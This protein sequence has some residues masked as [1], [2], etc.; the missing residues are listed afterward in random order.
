VRHSHCKLLRS[1]LLSIALVSYVVAHAVAQQDD[2]DARFDAMSKSFTSTAASFGNDAVTTWKVPSAFVK[3]QFIAR[4]LSSAIANAGITVTVSFPGQ[5]VNAPYAKVT[6]QSIDPI[7]C[8]ADRGC[9]SDCGWDLGCIAAKFDCERIKAQEKLFCE[10]KK[11]AQGAISDKL[12]L[13]VYLYDIDTGESDKV[14][15][16]SSGAAQV[17]GLNVADDLKAAT[18]VTNVS[19]SA[20]VST[21]AKFVFEAVLKALLVLLTANPTCIAD[22]EFFI[23]EQSVGFDQANLQLP[24]SL[25]DPYVKDDQLKID[26]QFQKT[27]ITLRFQRSP[28]A[29]LIESDWRNLRNIASCPAIPVLSVITEEFF[30]NDMMKKDQD[31]PAISQTQTLTSM[32]APVLAGQEYRVSLITTD[33]AIGLRADRKP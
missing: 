7:P 15:I 23:K 22:E 21:K 27:T 20:L 17:S 12:I 24:I 31:L 1:T 2:V 26:V 29:K 32:P 14:W 16:T 3:R 30:P 5:H 11:T 8:N 19:A 28:I 4:S 33:S 6:T 25:S 18:L 9:N 10:A 13:T